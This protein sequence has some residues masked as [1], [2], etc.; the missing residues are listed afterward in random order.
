MESEQL[1]ETIAQ[2]ITKNAPSVKTVYGD[3]IITGE[4]TIIPVA[5][6]AY[7][8]GGGFGQAPKRKM[9]GKTEE[10]TT[11]EKPSGEGAGGGGGVYSKAKGVYEI[12]PTT[13]R[14]IPADGM[15]QFLLGITLG[16]IIKALFFSKK[17]R[18]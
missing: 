11:Q 12:T 15:K 5:R 16:F 8:F 3:P 2:G 6:I 14:F 10:T 4:K 13:T 7:G 18:R 17:K 1:V 9:M